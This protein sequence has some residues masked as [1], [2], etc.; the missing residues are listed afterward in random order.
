MRFIALSTRFVYPSERDKR[1]YQ[2]VA[3]RHLSSS[4]KS[5]GQAQ[6]K[7]IPLAPLFNPLVVECHRRKFIASIKETNA[8]NHPPL[9]SSTNHNIRIRPT[10]GPLTLKES[11]TR[12]PLGNNPVWIILDSN[13]SR[14]MS[15]ASAIRMCRKAELGPPCVQIAL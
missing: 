15:K 12:L 11:S 8:H 14:G 9:D 3:I 1:A 6:P 2:C 5:N 4:R 13:S 7:D 10:K